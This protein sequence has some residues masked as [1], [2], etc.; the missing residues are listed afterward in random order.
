[1]RNM[2]WWYDRQYWLKEQIETC[3]DE[4]LKK[5]LIDEKDRQ[6]IKCNSW[7]PV[8]HYDSGAMGMCIHPK[9]YGLHHPSNGCGTVEQ[10]LVFIPAARV[11]QEI[12]TRWNFGCLL[13]ERKE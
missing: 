3:T 4:N 1:M 7:K 5:F 2:E 11:H 10:T 6:C 12:E 8:G 13:W 9:V